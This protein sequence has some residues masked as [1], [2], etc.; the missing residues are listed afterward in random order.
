MIIFV[1]IV[2]FP[3]KHKLK[4]LLQVIQV[5]SYNNCWEFWPFLVSPGAWLSDMCQERYEVREKKNTKKRP[6][7]LKAMG[8]MESDSD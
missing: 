6:T 1:I 3:T 4:L 8:S 5:G 2:K 7:G